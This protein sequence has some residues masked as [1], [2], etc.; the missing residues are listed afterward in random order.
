MKPTDNVCSRTFLDKRCQRFIG[1]GI[2]VVNVA[3]RMGDAI[4]QLLLVTEAERN[5]VAPIQRK[6]IGQLCYCLK[7]GITGVVQLQRKMVERVRPV[8][9][10][11]IGGNRAVWEECVSNADA[12][13]LR[14]FDAQR[15][16]QWRGP[17]TGYGDAAIAVK[18]EWAGAQVR[19]ADGRIVGNA[20]LHADRPDKIVPYPC[21]RKSVGVP[22]SGLGPFRKYGPSKSA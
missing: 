20:V 6:V 2:A 8:E 18:H 21:V 10:H 1:N 9:P 14:P 13:R 16:I 11:H 19:I 12:D 17:Q 3:L 4:V 7:I 15:G 22:A 5:A